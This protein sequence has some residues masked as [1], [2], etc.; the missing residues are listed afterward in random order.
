L[1]TLALV[2]AMSMQAPPLPRAQLLAER[3]RLEAL[4]P[5]MLG[6]VS[7]TISGSALC[8]S[9]A[10]WSSWVLLEALAGG[11]VTALKAFIIGVLAVSGA[12]FLGG[13]IWW[14]KKVRAERAQFAPPLQEIDSLLEE[15]AAL[16]IGHNSGGL[17]VAW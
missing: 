4:Q 3:A 10:L 15:N 17:Q 5:P 8:L 6:A 16:P 13:G 1:I 12:G 11:P 7:M 9:F 2:L 14:L